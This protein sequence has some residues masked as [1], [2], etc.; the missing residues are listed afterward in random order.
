VDVCL[1]PTGGGRSSGG[2]GGGESTSTSGGVDSA[3]VAAFNDY[4]AKMI[5]AYCKW[6]VGCGEVEEGG[7]AG[8]EADVGPEVQEEVDGC[9]AAATFYTDNR[10][11]LDACLDGSKATCGG[12]D[13]DNFCPTM[14]N[15]DSDICKGGSDDTGATTGDDPVTPPA[16]LS[17]DAQAVGAWWAKTTD[18]PPKESYE[19]ALYICPGGHIRGAGKFGTV[20]ELMC[21]TYETSP[22][23]LSNCTDKWGCFPKIAIKYKSTFILAG[24][25]DVEP[26]AKLDLRQVAPNQL[27][28]SWKCNGQD[29][30]ASFLR[31]DGEVSDM[32]CSSDAC[33]ASGS[34]ESGMGQCGTDCD[35]GHCWYCES[36]TCRYGGKGPSGCYRGCPWT[37]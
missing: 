9:E 26:A 27:L 28:R 25:K 36:G 4:I 6:L 34:A 3:D 1:Q 12:D 20:T 21:G 24:Q 32:D 5:P 7:Q 15:F 30:T 18:C 19:M 31:V 22:A 33:S 29:T 2:G 13:I 37:D 14:G 35:C 17:L 11:A 8:C 23:S 10:A 16:T